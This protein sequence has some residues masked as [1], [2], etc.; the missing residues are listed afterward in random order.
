MTVFK[1]NCPLCTR[2]DLELIYFGDFEFGKPDTSP[3]R[4]HCKSCDCVF[5]EKTKIITR[6]KENA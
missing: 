3:N 6:G 2:T 5:E 4:Y 1:L